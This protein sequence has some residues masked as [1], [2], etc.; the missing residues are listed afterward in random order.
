MTGHTNNV[1][2]LLPWASPE[3][4]PCFL[5]PGDGTGYVSRLADRVET[6][7][8]GLAAVLIEEA[9]KL[10]HGRAWTSG[11]LHLLAVELT[12]SLDTVRR[13]AESRGARL[14]VA[15]DDID[16]EIDGD[17]DG[18]DMQRASA[19]PGSPVTR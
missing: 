13:V 1:P 18:G 14:P 7:Q 16:G 10:L 8:L 15:G 2:R 5:L 19:N 12:E 9:R 3:G 17:A 4:K 11:E 6:E